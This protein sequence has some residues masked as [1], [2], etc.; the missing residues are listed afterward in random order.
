[1]PSDADLLDRQAMYTSL[2][3]ELP[4]SQAIELT[5]THIE[6]DVQSVG[7]EEIPT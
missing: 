4:G 6:L 3:S 2:E 1:V 5:S 7:S